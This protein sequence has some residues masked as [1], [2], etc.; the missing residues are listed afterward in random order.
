M[1][2]ICKK[3]G[4]TKSIE[5]FTKSPTCRYGR[6][7]CCIDCNHTYGKL[8]WQKIKP[9]PKAKPTEKVCNECGIKYPMT[10]EYFF[11]KTT[12]YKLADGTMGQCTS[13]RWICKK[14][15]GENTYLRKK[16]EVCKEY[17]CELKDYDETWKKRLSQAKT[18]YA[19]LDIPKHRRGYILH[20]IKNRYH[21]TTFEQ[22]KKDLKINII[23]G[24][25]SRRK[26]DYGDVDYI[27]SDMRNKMY[28]KHITDAR[29]A[30]SIGLS[31]KDVPKEII[32][33]K[34]LLIMLKREAGFT[35]S[36]KK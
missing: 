34:R 32:E 26:Y 18:L 30:L 6:T 21:Y 20:R 4:E 28:M 22:Y 7:F 8:R 17:G 1:K 33:V 3:C 35:H 11:T 31:V 2:R 9:A 13:F 36:T 25:K 19:E 27:T 12:K 23:N 15:H 10:K 24:S 5:D 14:C 29:I 16:K